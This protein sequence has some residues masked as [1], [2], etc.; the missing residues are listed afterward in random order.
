M[1]SSTAARKAKYKAKHKTKPAPPP[2]KK[3]NKKAYVDCEFALIFGSFVP[4]VTCEEIE[5]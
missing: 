5:T 3:L 1:S 2:D 4:L